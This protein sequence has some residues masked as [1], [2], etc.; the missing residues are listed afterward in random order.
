MTQNQ[1]WQ[2]LF[3]PKPS[4]VEHLGNYL[5]VDVSVKR[6]DLNHSLVQGNKLRKLKYNLKL[7]ILEKYRC[8]A[9]FG[10]AWSSHI[11]ATATAASY[12]GL[13][14][15]GFIRGD[16]LKFSKNKWS[17]TLKSAEQ[18]GMK[19][20]FLSRQDYRLKLT[21]PPVKSILEESQNKV[22]LIPEGGSN[23]LAVQG[24]EEI[25]VEMKQQIT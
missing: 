7:A 22:Y 21:A 20:V 15:I 4:P 13:D 12:C 24:V 25:I 16:E 1:K 17:T 3:N 6:D 19:L 2:Q 5:G 14:S 8:V 10:G 18:Q 9:T 11:L 23:S